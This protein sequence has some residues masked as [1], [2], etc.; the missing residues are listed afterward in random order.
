MREKFGCEVCDIL[1]LAQVRCSNLGTGATLQ[2]RRVSV[3]T[4]YP[5]RWNRASL[6]EAASRV[7]LPPA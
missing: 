4:L 6:A 7:P 5:E 2:V 1:V 3:L